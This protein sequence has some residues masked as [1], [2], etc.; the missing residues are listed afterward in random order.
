[1]LE[2]LFEARF[3]RRVPPFAYSFA[4]S[5]AGTS[6]WETNCVNVRDP[7]VDVFLH[8]LTHVKT[9]CQ[10]LFLAI[11]CA[12]APSAASKQF[13]RRSGRQRGLGR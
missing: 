6:L 13:S 3:L 7:G 5:T 8:L 4:I 10:T 12:A 11:G 9:S 2:T 1:M